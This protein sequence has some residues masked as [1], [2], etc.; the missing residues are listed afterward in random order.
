MFGIGSA[1]AVVA[2]LTRWFGAERALARLTGWRLSA[3]MVPALLVR[4][5]LLPV[6]WLSAW[7]G[8]GFVWRGTPMIAASTPAGVKRR[9][10]GQRAPHVGDRAV[11][12]T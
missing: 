3:R 12:E 4:D 11:Q 6:L 7:L 1:R 10:R 5:L 8:D 2:V 9:W